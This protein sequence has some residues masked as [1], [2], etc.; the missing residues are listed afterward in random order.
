[1]TRVFFCLGNN[2]YEVIGVQYTAL[3]ENANNEEKKNEPGAA[4]ASACG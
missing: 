1:M 4:L 3:C 2:V